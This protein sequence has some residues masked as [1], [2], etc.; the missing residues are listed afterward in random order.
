MAKAVGMME[1][2]GA[3]LQR[4]RLLAGIDQVPV[5]LALGRGLAEIQDAVLGVKDRL[6]A[7]RLELRHH[8]GKADAEIDI[9]AV[10][11]VLRGAPG[12]LRVGKLR[13][14]MRRPPPARISASSC[15]GIGD[16]DDA[17]DEDAGCDDLLGVDAAGFDDRGS[18]GR[19]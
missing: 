3:R 11:D 10:L 2:C 18:P 14:L 8:L 7:R 9:G 12:D 1:E 15:A 19:S 4:H 17:I 5:L 13:R 6:P 16:L